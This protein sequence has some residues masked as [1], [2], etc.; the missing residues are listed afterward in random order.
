MCGFPKDTYYFYQSQWTKTPM[1]HLLPHWNWKGKEGKEIPVMAYS[2]CETVE[3][4]LNGRSLGEQAMERQMNLLWQ[5]PYE[6]GVLMALGKKGDRV[7][8]ITKITTAGNPVKIQL[9]ADR[10]TINADKQDVVHV[11]VS[12]L[13]KEGIFV[14]DASNRMHFKT[15]GEATIIAVDNG[16]PM[17]EESY[18]GNNRK[19]FNGKCLVILKSTGESGKFTLSAEAIGL[20]GAEVTIKTKKNERK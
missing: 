16:D 17:N 11:E 1:V 14:P 6:P 19:A 18:A 7:I 3:L 15:E 5:V 8:C 10:E 2:N 13:D 20:E 9:L 12:I 4:F